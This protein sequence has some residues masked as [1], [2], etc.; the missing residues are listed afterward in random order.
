MWKMF[1]CILGLIGID[2][3]SKSLAMR[4]ETPIW[5]WVDYINLVPVWNHGLS[6]GMCPTLCKDTGA[7]YIM[8]FFWIVISLVLSRWASISYKKKNRLEGIS[9]LLISAGA[10]GNTIDRIYHRAVCD[11]VHIYLYFENFSLPSLGLFFTNQIFPAFNIA[12]V[13]LTV[14]FILMSIAMYRKK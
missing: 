14:G 4:I 3:I 12:D 5:V 2:Q 10:W 1:L 6:W 8:L 13:F 9:L 11:F 7:F